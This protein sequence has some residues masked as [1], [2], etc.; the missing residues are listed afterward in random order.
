MA[1]KK[2]KI[3]FMAQ[4]MFLLESTDLNNLLLSRPDRGTPSIRGIWLGGGS[5]SLTENVFP[6]LE[7]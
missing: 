4:M 5:E 7:V 6:Q 1:I 3:T 2:F